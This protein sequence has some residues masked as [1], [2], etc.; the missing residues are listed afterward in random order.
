MTI[1]RERLR[2]A[3]RTAECGFPRQ[4]CN[5]YGYRRFTPT[6]TQRDGYMSLWSQ[7][8]SGGLVYFYGGFGVGKTLLA[9]GA[10]FQWMG[11]H[12]RGKMPEGIS[13]YPKYRNARDLFDEQIAWQRGDMSQESPVKKAERVGLLV[14]DELGLSRF[15]DFQSTEIASIV[16]R[17]FTDGKPTV[18]I[19]N[20]KPED[21]VDL[22]LSPLVLDRTKERGR[23]INAARWKNMRDSVS[24]ASG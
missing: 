17:R 23:V 9:T 6:S 13:G 2:I 7:I 18:L 16:L 14:I 19:A 10:G 4:H 12:D 20:E 21:I 22:G 11:L 3:Q 8:R 15:T 24:K 1:D 5:E